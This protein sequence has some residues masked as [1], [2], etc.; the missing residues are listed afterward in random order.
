ME[1]ELHVSIVGFY[2]VITDEFYVF[3]NAGQAIDYKICSFQGYRIILETRIEIE[4]FFIQAIFGYLEYLTMTKYLSE[5]R[6]LV[7]VM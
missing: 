4:S 7:F 3:G 5:N 2:T 1:V 6:M